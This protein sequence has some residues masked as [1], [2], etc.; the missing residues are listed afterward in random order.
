MS[1]IANINVPNAMVIVSICFFIWFRHYAV[2]RSSAM[3]C[4]PN[5]NDS[6]G[7]AAENYCTFVQA[8]LASRRFHE[9]RIWG[10]YPMA[11]SRSLAY[12]FG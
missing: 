7:A 12:Y 6:P 3:G 9:K 4:N 8:A 10:K 2:E 11:K 1:G 5:R